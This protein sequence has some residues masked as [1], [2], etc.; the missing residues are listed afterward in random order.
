MLVVPPPN[1]IL[2]GIFGLILSKWFRRA[3]LTITSVCLVLLLLLSLPFIS[4]RLLISLE[5]E[6]P[7]TV[8]GD[9]PQAIV[10]LSAETEHVLGP[11]PNRVVG[12]LTL[13]REA[14]AAILARR[15]GLPVLVSGGMLW[16]D[17]IPLGALMATSMTQTFGVTPR[18]VEAQSRTT[19][20]N[21]EYS[22]ALLAPLGIHSV[23]VVTHAWHMPRAILAFRH[24]G[25]NAAPAVVRWDDTASGVLPNA[26][27]WLDSYFALH[28]WIGLGWYWMKEKLT[29]SMKFS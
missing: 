8:A 26:T 3:G 15:T 16:D 10:V 17:N 23:Y 18:W 4:S 11:G 21:A 1:L 29:G 6:V 22:A 7:R 5:D 27:A 2:I 9:P 28:E 25:L 19:W 24:F 20:E 14:A 13:E 12:P